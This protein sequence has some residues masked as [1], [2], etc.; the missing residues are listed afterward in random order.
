MA[1]CHW[2][3]KVTTYFDQETVEKDA[4]ETHLLV[5]A[6]CREHLDILETVRQYTTE[7]RENTPKIRDEQM[8]A[9]MRG[10]EDALAEAPVKSHKSL[11]AMLSLVT[12]ALV[13][14]VATF[15]I[16]TGPGPAK[17]TEIE[18]VSTELEGATVE[19]YDMDN[20]VT[21]VWINVS[22]DDVW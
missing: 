13:M 17:A 15:S 19:W 5:C 11:W 10:I 6:D 21:T 22:E 12:A 4:V 9:F 20:G 7:V 2:E 18:S 16:F 3:R 14:A 1:A 8:P